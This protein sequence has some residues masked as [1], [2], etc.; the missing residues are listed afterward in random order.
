MWSQTSPPP[1]GKAILSS[2]VVPG[3]ENQTKRKNQDTSIRGSGIYK[4]ALLL[5]SS[6]LYEAASRD[7]SPADPLAA[8]SQPFI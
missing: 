8:G 5:S 7:A 3:V 2:R 1:N 6:G 4:H